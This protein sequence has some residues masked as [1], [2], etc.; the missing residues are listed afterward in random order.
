VIDGSTGCLVPKGDDA[1]LA[2]ALA[3]VL[4][5]GELRQQLRDGARR[6]LAQSFSSARMLDR[7]AEAYLE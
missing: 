7:L 6:H 4:G 5:S 3:A 1:A 2:R